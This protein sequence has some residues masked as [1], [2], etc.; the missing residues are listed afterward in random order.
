[1][2]QQQRRSPYTIL[3]VQPD[4]TSKEI[5]LAYRRKAMQLH[6]DR[7]SAPDALDR[8]REVRQCYE[9]LISP[10][11]RALIDRMFG[12]S[13][14]PGQPQQPAAGQKEV[15]FSSYTAAA[16]GQ[17]DMEFDLGKD[18]S[19]LALVVHVLQLQSI[20]FKTI[21]CIPL[22][23]LIHYQAI[24]FQEADIE[25]AAAAGYIFM[26]ALVAAAAGEI[27]IAFASLCYRWT[28]RKVVNG[29]VCWAIALSVLFWSGSLFLN[30]TGL[31]EIQMEII[32]NASWLGVIS[33]LYA[34]VVLCLTFQRHDPTWEVL[35][36]WIGIAGLAVVAVN[37]GYAFEWPLLA[38]VAAE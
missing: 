36:I 24:Q 38:P 4:A 10:V 18:Y 14:R 22:M 29:I 6:P 32:A 8:F 5:E 9:L 3:G 26:H 15:D 12:F 25:L 13:R 1:M 19:L 21:V 17:V 23:A 37:L 34:W 7:N 35:F 33:S 2:K 27:I 30:A 11:S 31:A 16:A 28:V 20:P